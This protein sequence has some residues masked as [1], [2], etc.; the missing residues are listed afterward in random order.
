[1]K[2]GELRMKQEN[3]SIQFDNEVIHKEIDLI[4]GII[5]RMGQN[6]FFIKGWS[7]ALVVGFSAFIF[8]REKICPTYAIATMITQIVITLFLWYLDSFFL[9]TERFY[10]SWY[11]FC[12]VK[13]RHYTREWKYV[14][15]MNDIKIIMGEEAMQKANYLPSRNKV[16]FSKTLYLFYITVLLYCIIISAYFVIP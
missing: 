15:N 4:Q 12:I 5:N 11:D 13:K 14:L 6:S 16:F 9:Y 8:S 10:R 7:V 3:D 2:K 1:M